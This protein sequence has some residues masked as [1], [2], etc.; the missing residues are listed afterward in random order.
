MSEPTIYFAV[1]SWEFSPSHSFNTYLLNA[2]Y[3][4][5][6]L[7]SAGDTAVNESEGCPCFTESSNLG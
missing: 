1:F 5:D 7:Q 4:L 6:S 2:Y 3:G